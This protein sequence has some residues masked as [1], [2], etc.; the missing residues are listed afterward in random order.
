MNFNGYRNHECKNTLR[1]LWCVCVSNETLIR[2]IELTSDLKQTLKEIYNTELKQSSF[3]QTFIQ[4]QNQGF[5][6]HQV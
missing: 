6:N 2:N 5:I 3:T 1:K 4:W